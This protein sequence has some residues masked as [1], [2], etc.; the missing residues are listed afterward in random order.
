MCHTKKKNAKF[1]MPSIDHGTVSKRNHFPSDDDTINRNKR[2][3]TN[4][5]FISFVFKL[6][7]SPYNLLK[8]EVTLKN[9]AQIHNFS[10]HKNV[11]VTRITSNLS[12]SNKFI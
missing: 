7:M 9:S 6:A 1:T 8:H 3:T 5:Q 4:L 10:Y 12:G 2:W 11:N